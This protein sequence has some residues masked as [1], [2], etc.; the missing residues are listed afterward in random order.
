MSAK[1]YAEFLKLQGESVVELAGVPWMKYQQAIVP[2]TAM[3]VYVEPS[4]EEII[5]T[6]QQTKALFLRYTT[7]SQQEKTNWWYMICR[8]YDFQD[9]SSNTRSKIRRGLKRLTIEKISPIWLAEHGYNCHVQSY[10]RY[11]HASPL[12]RDQFR[13]FVL[14][15]QDQPLFDL[16]SCQKEGD[17]LG[18]LICL[19]EE[20]GVFLHTIDLTPEG[21]RLYAAY[22]MLHQL[23]EYYLNKRGMPVSNGSRSIAHATQMQDFLHKFGFQKEYAQLHVVYRRDVELVVRI[24]YPFKDLLQRFETIPLIHKI[25]AVLSQE[26]LVRQQSISS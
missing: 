6:I 23:L 2:A 19:Q 10:Q 18:Y 8:H 25:S 5:Q 3:P 9:V 17:L 24:L 11:Q 15:L 22:A 21:L 13:A 7:I 26:E 20:D 14:S 12:N 1:S 4:Q 16:W